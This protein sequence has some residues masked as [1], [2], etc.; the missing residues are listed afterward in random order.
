MS[1]RY[2]AVVLVAGAVGIVAQAGES[3]E[4][5]I[6]KKQFWLSL[7]WSKRESTAVW[8]NGS[9]KFNDKDSESFKSGF[10]KKSVFKVG[11]TEFPITANA[12]EML[13]IGG[14]PK[15]TVEECEALQAWAIKAFGPPTVSIDNS[16]DKPRNEEGLVPTVKSTNYEW[17]LKKTRASSVCFGE[18]AGG[19]T[20]GPVLASL[21]F[22]SKAALRETKPA[23]ILKCSV[24]LNSI[25]GTIIKDK[26]ETSVY[27]FYI[28]PNFEVVSSYPEK[29]PISTEAKFTEDAITFD[30]ALEKKSSTVSIDR[31]T[32]DY[33]EE[34]TLKEPA[35][36][37][38][39]TGTC[40]KVDLSRP[41]KF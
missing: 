12:K 3:L 32:G 5:L 33:R 16:Y 8:K 27:S 7:D 4:A 19:K 40:S 1:I 13:A 26:M 2:V 31:A 29:Y 36:N 28:D 37:G 9:W 30:I 18:S 20:T 14:D 39:R 38:V 24:R 17:D 11:E 23:I 34:I 25:D 35:G 10:I 41:K 21:S 15:T 6:G 22:G